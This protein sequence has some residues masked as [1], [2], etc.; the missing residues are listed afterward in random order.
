MIIYVC[1][2]LR[3]AKLSLYTKLRRSTPLMHII[4]K[5]AVWQKF[6]WEKSI[7]NVCMK[8]LSVIS[9]WWVCVCMRLCLCDAYNKWRF[10]LRIQIHINMYIIKNTWHLASAYNFN[11]VSVRDE[12]RRR[13]ASHIVHIFLR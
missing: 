5:A 3:Q 4:A 1:A 12:R 13:V 7:R 2:N 6:I 9:C 10:Y 11:D 8:I